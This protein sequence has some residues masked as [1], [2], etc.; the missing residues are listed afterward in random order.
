ML[1]LEV[2]ALV[3]LAVLLA[4]MPLKLYALAGGAQTRPGWRVLNGATSLGAGAVV[5]MLA[6]GG[7]AL[8]A[9]PAEVAAC[10]CATIIYSDLRYFLIPDLCTLA[11][12]AAG[13]VNAATGGLLQAAAGAAV[14][15]LMLLLVI[16]I[17]RLRGIDGMGF[18]DVKLGFAL[19]AL[20][21]P[22]AMAWAL[23]LSSF[24]GLTW[25]L[26]GY[27]CRRQ[28]F[29]VIPYGAALAAVA[30]VILCLKASG[31]SIAPSWL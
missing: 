14:G 3:P 21:G 2:S 24:L 31:V 23:C 9:I 28:R 16:Y 19:G 13:I 6:S 20:L 15:G 26:L 22:V 5:A 11:I 7:P 27:L 30:I 25:A 29:D 10:A 18:G 17:G 4:T 12:L 1:G 8:E